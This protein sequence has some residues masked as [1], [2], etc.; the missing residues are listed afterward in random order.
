MD[1]S[2]RLGLLAS[3]CLLIAAPAVAQTPPPAADAPLFD[4]KPIGPGV[5]A[6]IGGPKAGS[7]AGFVIGDNGVLV[8]DAFFNPDAA[9]ALLIEIHKLTDKPILYLVNTHFHIDHVRG[10]AVFKAAGATII[11]HRNVPGWVHPEN[12]HLLG[13][14][15][16]QPQARADVDALIGPDQT[17]D[18]TTVLTLGRR[19]I[20][21]RPMTGHTGGDLVVG[22]PDAHVLFA[23]DLLWNHTGP[24]T[25]DG[26]VVPWTA[27]L[28]QLETLSNTTFVPGHGQVATAKEV[29]DLK[30]FFEDLQRLTR[31]A[32]AKGLSGDALVKDTA[33]KLAALHTGWPRIEQNAPFIVAEMDQELAGTKRVPIPAK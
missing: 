28:A 27:E 32:R 29:D 30:V 19:K 11:A 4:L 17:V 18:K 14:D 1:L 31:E 2:R 33:P 10:D 25:I 26:K 13:G 22:V 9:K 20:E 24:T 23:G 12:I 7:N 3:L 15:K 16:I 21:L 8:V 6:A 5:Y